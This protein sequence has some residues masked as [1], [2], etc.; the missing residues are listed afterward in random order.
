MG[1]T[2][3]R[4]WLK[5]KLKYI[6]VLSIII[7]LIMMSGCIAAK[8]VH[9]PHEQPGQTE[10][11]DKIPNQDDGEQDSNESVELIVTKPEDNDVSKTG[12]KGEPSKDA[13]EE[14]SE[15]AKVDKPVENETDN[16]KVERTPDKDIDDKPVEKPTEK[17]IEAKPPVEQ[18][19]KPTE[20]IKYEPLS[21]EI[22]KLLKLKYGRNLLNDAEKALYDK[23]YATIDN[24]KQKVNLAE[25]GITKDLLLKI[26][27][28][29]RN[30]S[31]EHYWIENIRYTY[32]SNKI[33]TDVTLGYNVTL[34]EKKVLD[35]KIG[36]AV[37][38][39]LQGLNS[40]ASEYDKIKHL[41][42]YIV[43][44][45]EYGLSSKHNQNIVSVLV[46]KI[47]VC[48]GYSK[49]MQYLLNKVGIEC[50][51]IEGTSDGMGHAWNIV[52]IGG[53]YYNLDVT[54]DD[55]IMSKSMDY[56][57]NFISYEF[58]LVTDAQLSKTHKRDSSSIPLPI[59]NNTSMNYYAQEGL[60]FDKFDPAVVVP[61]VVKLVNNR[62]QCFSF[63]FSTEEGYENYKD[64]MSENWRSVLSAVNAQAGNVIN[65]MS[66]SY[67]PSDR[68]CIITMVLSYK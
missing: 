59:C 54:W 5:N 67:I 21:P 55:P 58:F 63:K 19:P 22:S 53:K 18:T 10:E 34:S 3:M 51:W 35:T 56:Y 13:E 28:I 4:F 12:E 68:A 41:H 30:D 8:N 9:T 11:P 36:A 17:P 57:E 20:D 45:T 29:Y 31:P 64:S 16:S 46:D 32:N 24:F 39:A 47:S 14:P 44:R 2:N 6:L 52:K 49:T 7:S 60:L 26:Y 1:S 25:Y 65:E 27:N 42:D 23:L 48:A 66:Y 40:G 43:L 61:K 15:P 50:L 33:V 37:N 38:Q 62:A